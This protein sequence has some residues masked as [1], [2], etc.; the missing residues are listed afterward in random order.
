MI[1]FLEQSHLSLEPRHRSTDEACH[2][3]GGFPHSG[4]GEPDAYHQEV[5][6]CAKT[7]LEILHGDA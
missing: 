4:Q 3:F 5:A 1:S 6:K 2:E 7:S